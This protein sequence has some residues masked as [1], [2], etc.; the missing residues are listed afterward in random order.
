MAQVVVHPTSKQEVRGSTPEPVPM[1]IFKN[2]GSGGSEPTLN[3]RS[4]H[5]E[6]SDLQGRGSM[7]RG[8]LLGGFGVILR[9]LFVL[10]LEDSI[11]RKRE[12][13]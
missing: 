4:H 8:K 10:I 11:T 2:R 3:C 7:S 6:V 13:V 9:D 12:R 5:K 1:E